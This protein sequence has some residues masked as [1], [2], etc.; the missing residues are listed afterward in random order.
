[1][2]SDGYLMIIPHNFPS[3]LRRLPPPAPSL[4]HITHNSLTS[5]THL[6]QPPSLS[7][8]ISFHTQ[9]TYISHASFSTTTFV[10]RYLSHTAHTQLC[11]PSFTP[12]PCFSRRWRRGTLRGRR[13]PWSSTF[14]WRGRRGTWSHPPSFCM[15]GVALLVLGGALSCR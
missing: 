9:L 7:H 4:T 1:M 6:C 14:V 13:A 15:A 12:P 11:Q 10:T 3:L 2:A 8:T 5:H